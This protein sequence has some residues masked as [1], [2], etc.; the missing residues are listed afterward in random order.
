MHVRLWAAS[1]F[2]RIVDP[3]V[4]IG[5]R[6][7]LRDATWR[8]VSRSDKLLA[9]RSSRFA[10]RRRA[11]YDFRS[12]WQENEKRERKNIEIYRRGRWAKSDDADRKMPVDRDAMRNLE[13][14]SLCHV[15][16]HVFTP[17]RRWTVPP[18]PPGAG[19]GGGERESNDT[20][21]IRVFRSTDL[22]DKAIQ[23]DRFVS[24]L[25]RPIF[26]SSLRAIPRSNLDGGMVRTVVRL[27]S[28]FL[29][30]ILRWKS[31]SYHSRIVSWKYVEYLRIGYVC[32]FCC[33]RTATL[34]FTTM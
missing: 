6:H 31:R 3:H 11:I 28:A 7:F 23:S 15:R 26:V 27:I 25:F 13:T 19:G 29:S 34:F 16:M 12:R 18:P 21:A 5:E 14:F 2:S 8:D 32:E 22:F 17:I 9:L 10:V 1:R 30:E 33:N 24:L 20:R 4:D